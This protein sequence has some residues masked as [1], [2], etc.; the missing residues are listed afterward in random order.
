MKAIIPNFNYNS[1]RPLYLELYD[2]I[3]KLILSKEI[4][5]N[6]KLP[7]L[8]ALSKN[9]SI[10]LTTVELAYNQLMVEGY[11]K[12]KPQSGYY[13]NKISAGMGTP[14][15]TV[16]ESTDNRLLTFY[17]N[18]NMYHDLSCFDFTK[19]KK[20]FNSVLTEHSHLLLHESDPQGEAALRY[21]ISKYV[22]Q[23]RGV[24]CTPDQIVIGAG[25]Q[26]ITSQLSLL[27]SKIDIKHV[28][29][30]EPG[31]LPVIN[32]FG[33]RS[34][35]IS[36]I[37]VDVDGIRIAKLPF[38]IRAAV[39]VNPSSQFPTGYVMP[40]GRRYELLN[41]AKENDSIIIEDDYDSEL[42]YFGKPVPSLQ[43][44]DTDQRVVYL[45]SFSSTLF[46]SIKISYM[47]LPLFMAE[48]FKS[49]SVGYSQTCSKTEQLTLAIYMGKGLY[50][51]NIKKLR[52]LY[53]QKLALITSVLQR[54]G[55]NFILPG[56]NSSG[57]NMLINIKSNK[58]SEKLCQ[59]AKELGIITL[60]IST[61]TKE[62]KEEAH[63]K[64]LVFYY[65]QI[66]LKSI[67][68]AIIDLVNKWKQVDEDC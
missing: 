25:T 62:N 4:A 40:V 19:W 67:E 63:L 3:K 8:R 6:E 12:S 2:E 28:A 17:D 27:L 11:I 49:I 26:Q 5:P 55:N 57:I 50:Q 65:N 1:K 21:E 16:V 14:P 30:E 59:E 44:L 60:P 66:P 23:S 33:D 20:C 34:F 29:V 41:W 37:P 64:T 24:I 42:R 10:S 22:Y 13:A 38:N 18:S 39:Y 56:G 58:S 53:S 61:F 32:I 31:Y 68:T 35:A 51:I 54:H 47:I 46:P 9:L 7:S 48:I 52:N 45:G 15:A 43:G 36:H